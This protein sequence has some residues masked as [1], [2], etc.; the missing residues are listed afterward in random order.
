MIYSAAHERVSGP[1]MDTIRLHHSRGYRVGIESI[2]YIERQ[3]GEFEGGVGMVGRIKELDEFV[4][5]PYQGIVVGYGDENEKAFTVIGVKDLGKQG[6]SFKAGWFSAEGIDKIVC[7]LQKGIEM[8]VGIV[9]R[10]LDEY[11]D[12]LEEKGFKTL[13]PSDQAGE[14]SV[15]IAVVPREV[16]SG[17]V[18]NFKPGF[19]FS[20]EQFSLNID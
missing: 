17:G 20:Y 18:R 15:S 1:F 8:A 5:V 4:D 16:V 2:M 13:E 6:F 10:V 7:H 9:P 11:R 14:S 19:Y 12:D 3:V